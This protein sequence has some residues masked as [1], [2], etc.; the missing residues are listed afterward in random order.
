MKK[1]KQSKEISVFKQRL[2]FIA[3]SVVFL[4]SAFENFTDMNQPLIGVIYIF[5]G[6]ISIYLIKNIQK[7]KPVVHLVFNLLV[8]LSSVIVAL[9][10]KAMGSK[11]LPYIYFLIAIAYIFISIKSFFYYREEENIPGEIE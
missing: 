3:G 7:I 2:P 6:A 5:F 4:T 10:R 9:Q 1:K 8:A 11:N